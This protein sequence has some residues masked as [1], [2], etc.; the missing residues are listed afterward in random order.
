MIFWGE[1]APLG[2]LSQMTSVLQHVGAT[3][4]HVLDRGAGR[5]SSPDTHYLDEC[6]QKTAQEHYSLKH[7]LD[8]LKIINKP[9]RNA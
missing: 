5:M 4:E 7:L 8:G 6:L 2:N 3:Q 1:I 9:V